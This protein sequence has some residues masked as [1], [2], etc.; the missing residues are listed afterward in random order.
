MLKL[1]FVALLFWVTLAGAP[2]TALAQQPEDDSIP[3]PEGILAEF[4]AEAAGE[5]GDEFNEEAY[6]FDRG[7]LERRLELDANGIAI[8][9]EFQQRREQLESFEEWSGGERNPDAW[10]ELE[11]A[12]Q[13]RHDELQKQYQALDR[14]DQDYRNN[15]QREEIGNQRDEFEAEAAGRR[16]E[17]GDDF[18]EEAYEF[19]LGMMDRRSDLDEKRI[20]IEEEFQQKREQLESSG[21]GQNRNAWHELDQEEQR[22]HEELQKE[23]Q[24]L[25]RE[26]QDYWN[27]RLP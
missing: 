27:N 15:R 2:I 22:R 3:I 8:E 14:E 26:G 16:S 10:Q 4:E 21:G 25:D 18:D 20:K 17:E 9:E 1:K 5:E 23:Y 24:A 13:Q 7:L 19:E 11:E 12:Q 6:E